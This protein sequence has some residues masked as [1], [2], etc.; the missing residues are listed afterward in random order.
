MAITRAYSTRFPLCSTIPPSITTSLHFSDAAAPRAPQHQ[1]A[2]LPARWPPSNAPLHV[3]L[4]TLM[5]CHEDDDARL[6]TVC[7][8]LLGQYRQIDEMIEAVPSP[9]PQQLDVGAFAE[10]VDSLEVQC[11]EADKRAIFTMIDR[12]GSGSICASELRQALRSSGAI[13]SM[14]DGSLRTFGTLIAATLAFDVG[15]FALKGST[16][17]L[18]FLTAYA[19]EDS[20]SVD[21]LFV[22]LLIFRTFKV[23]PQTVDAC[24]N[25]GITGSIVLRGVFIFAGLAAVSAFNPLL[26][27]FSAFLLFSSY[28]LLTGD[29]D[30]DDLE[31]PQLVVDLLERLPM[32]NT[33]EGDSLYVKRTTAASSSRS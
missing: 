6:C 22:F 23:P 24:L 21:N 5:P 8:A 17:A 18:D 3:L 26:L 28:Q 31:L 15:V 7:V 32:T 30:D 13:K 33:F 1:L 27:G 19:V 20:L 2:T 25:Y 12:D 14:Y 10:L 16:A 9:V 11:S 29:D 4:C